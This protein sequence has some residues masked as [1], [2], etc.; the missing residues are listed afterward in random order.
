MANFSKYCQEIDNSLSFQWFC[1]NLS[2]YT[3]FAHTTFDSLLTVVHKL[4]WQAIEH[5][6]G[7]KIG[8][9]RRPYLQVVTNFLTVFL[10]NP[11]QSREEAC[12]LLC[13]ERLEKLMSVVVLKQCKQPF[14]FI[15]DCVIPLM[16]PTSSCRF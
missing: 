16:T 12:L 11:P 5:P 4:R 3:F 10:Q 9:L 8:C 7:T 14:S 2:R 6:M 1:F 13:R 15:Y